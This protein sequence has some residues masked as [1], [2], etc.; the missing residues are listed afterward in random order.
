MRSF[1]YDCRGPWEGSCD[2]DDHRGQ[3]VGRPPD[4]GRK[5]ARLSTSNL[6]AMTEKRWFPFQNQVLILPNYR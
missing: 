6:G 2:D 4:H 3:L 5:N 1:G